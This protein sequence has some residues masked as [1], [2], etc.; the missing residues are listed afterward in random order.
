MEQ[1]YERLVAEDGPQVVVCEGSAGLGKSAVVTDV[2]VRLTEQGWP[3]A[4][5]RMDG[6]DASA[7]TAKAWREPGHGRRVNRVVGRASWD[8][9]GAM[10][11]L[12]L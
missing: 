5:V 6:A 7:Q 9:A 12:R 8:G 4:A 10:P 2:L 1:L 3:A 11:C